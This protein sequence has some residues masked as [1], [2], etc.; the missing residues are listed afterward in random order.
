MGDGGSQTANR[1]TG[2]QPHFRPLDAAQKTRYA[3]DPQTEQG[4]CTGG[5]SAMGVKKTG[6]GRRKIGRKKRK[7]RS[8]IRHRKG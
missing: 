5:V 7:M 1:R 6:K 2:E 8:R 4:F 3:S